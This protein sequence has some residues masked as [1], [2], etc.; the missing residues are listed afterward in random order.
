MAT[1]TQKTLKRLYAL[2]GNICAFPGCNAPVVSATGTPTA[3]VCHICAKS[4]GGPRFNPE[5]TEQERNG[6]DNLLL[7]CGE[8]H[9]VV[10][11][12]P[13][14]Y[15]VTVLSEI[16]AVHE[17]VAGRPERQADLAVAKQLQKQLL[18]TKASRNSGNIAINSPGAKLTNIIN[19]NTRT[20]KTQ[21]EAPPGSIG[22][23]LAA[24][25]YCQHLINRYNDFASKE[26]SRS[27]KFSYAVISKNIETK[28][29]SQWRLLPTASAPE[30]FSYLQS[31]ID[32]TR[33]AKL[34]KSKGH[35][36]YS[37]YHEY[38]TKYAADD[39]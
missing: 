13:N 24:A 32:R 11:S 9:T 39:T 6:F 10:D 1:P 22:S 4:P 15:T 7:L 33:M 30:V 3:Q 2:S 37:T 21:I 18:D 16:K 20:S 19:I 27:G 38:L 14:T 25:R 17:A 23:D 28:F 31:R 12:E 29:G 34:N 5:Q 36:S 35:P 8:H 26:P